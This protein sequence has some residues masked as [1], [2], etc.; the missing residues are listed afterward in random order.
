MNTHS[1]LD[2]YYASERF[3]RNGVFIGIDC[4]ADNMRFIDYDVAHCMRCGR[5]AEKED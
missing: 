3:N 1:C 4:S 2:C 5:W